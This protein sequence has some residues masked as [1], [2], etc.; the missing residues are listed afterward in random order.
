M[1]PPS[2][3][4]K[5]TI[6]EPVLLD[7]SVNQEAEFSPSKIVKSCTDEL[8]S[9]LNLLQNAREHNDRRLVS[10]V[11]HHLPAIRRQLTAQIIIN[12]LNSS[13]ISSNL[14]VFYYLHLFLFLLSS[15]IDS[16]NS[17]CVD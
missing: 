8:I 9:Q 1:S 13:L 6:E 12:L 17:K 10:R 14:I 2:E 15:S 7:A 11:L 16:F 4:V 5:P 3:T